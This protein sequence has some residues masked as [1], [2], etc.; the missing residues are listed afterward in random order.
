MNLLFCGGADGGFDDLP[1]ASAI[2]GWRSVL[3]EKTPVAVLN[4]NL[5]LTLGGEF[6]R[7]IGIFGLGFTLLTS[8]NWDKFGAVG[9]D[10]TI[11]RK[12]SVLELLG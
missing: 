2:F 7:D 1:G 3:A 9:G 12:E 11:L 6:G 10:N 4:L 5:N 8:V